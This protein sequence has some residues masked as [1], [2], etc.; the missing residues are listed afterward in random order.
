[1]LAHIV[2]YKVC[3]MYF[4]SFTYK[5]NITFDTSPFVKL[6]RNKY[7]LTIHDLNNPPKISISIFLNAVKITRIIH[8]LNALILF[9]NIQNSL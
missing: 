9:D 4:V 8:F 7:T 5:E 2:D 1:M 3:K 6:I